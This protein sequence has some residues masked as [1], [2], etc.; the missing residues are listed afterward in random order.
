MLRFDIKESKSKRPKSVLVASSKKPHTKYAIIVVQKT[1]LPRFSSNRER[2]DKK[3]D[4][5]TSTFSLLLLLLLPLQYT[6]KDNK[7]STALRQYPMSM[8]QEVRGDNPRRRKCL[9]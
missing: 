6:S 5:T 1:P 8:T 4:Y 3:E 2:R 9:F 7:K